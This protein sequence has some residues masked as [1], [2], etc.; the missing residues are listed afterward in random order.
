MKGCLALLALVAARREETHGKGL[1]SD[2]ARLFDTTASPGTVYPRPHDLT[3][4]G[5]LEPVELVRTKEYYPAD[6]AAVRE[7]LRRSMHQHLALAAV[8]EAAL[9]TE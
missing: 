8:F 7:R 6:E 1:T 5:L 2:L 9:A 4:A 3:A